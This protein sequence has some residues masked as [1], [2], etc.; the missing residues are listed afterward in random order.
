MAALGVSPELV[1]VCE[2]WAELMSAAG[3]LAAKP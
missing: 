2:W 3:G 1:Q